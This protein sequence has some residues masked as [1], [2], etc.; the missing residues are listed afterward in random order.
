MANFN[1][2]DLQTQEEDLARRKQVIDALVTRGANSRMEQ[3]RQSFGA[4]PT[5]SAEME[6]YARDN[7]AFQQRKQQQ[8]QQELAQYMDRMQGTPERPAQGDGVGPPVPP[9]PANPREA[10]IRAMTSQ[11]PEMQAM[12]KSSMTA[13]GK[14]KDLKEHVIGNQLVV[15]DGQGNSRVAGTYNKAD[16]KDEDRTINGQVVPGRRNAQDNKWEAV[17]PTGTTVNVDT[18]GQSRVQ[19]DALKAMSGAREQVVAAQSQLESAQRVLELVDDPQV[20]TGFGAGAVSGFAALGAKLGLNGQEGV[21]KTQ[22]LMTDL[23]R[24]TLN[25]GQQMKGSFSD[26]DIQFLSD[27]TAGK[28]DYNAQ[29]IKHMASLAYAAGHNGMLSAMQQYSGAK[30]IPGL[31]GADKVYPL[32]EVRWD[33]T[34]GD[35]KGFSQ[36]AGGRLRYDGNLSAPT[37]PVGRV[38][39]QGRRRLTVDEFLGSGQ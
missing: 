13:F 7:S 11:L 36:G 4:A 38:N 39:S 10:I 3:V 23:A 12:G 16:W 1:D 35:R 26:K 21:A 33:A 28:V 25:A 22:A 15:S 9:Q 2:Y 31:T 14:P 30:E 37:T 6:A 20:Q 24:N 8:M 34:I 19:E 18:R 5:G 27:V 32:P 29:T 17:G